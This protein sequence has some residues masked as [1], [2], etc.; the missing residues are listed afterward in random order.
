[1]MKAEAHKKAIIL[2]ALLCLFTI[3]NC[4]KSVNGETISDAVITG[5]DARDCVCCGGLMINFNNDPVP[6]SGTF[7]LINELPVKPVIDNNTKFPLYVKITWSYDNKVCGAS[8]FV[9]ILKM[10]IK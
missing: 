10:E 6:Y 5:F 1:M 2:I 7:Y 4:Q 9:D 3:T 8:K